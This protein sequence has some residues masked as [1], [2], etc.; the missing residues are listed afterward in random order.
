MCTL[1]QIITIKSKLQS[2]YVYLFNVQKIEHINFAESKLSIIWIASRLRLR[3]MFWLN[4]DEG[5]QLESATRTR[6]HSSRTQWLKLGKTMKITLLWRNG[7]PEGMSYSY[8]TLDDVDSTLLHSIQ[9]SLTNIFSEL[10][11]WK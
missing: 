8:S 7:L 9:A 4:S 10:L 1:I 11:K 6:V 2:L 5:G 3:K